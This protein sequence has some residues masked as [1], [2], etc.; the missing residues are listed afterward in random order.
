LVGLARFAD[1]R[2]HGVDT[3]DGLSDNTVRRI[4]QEAGWENASPEWLDGRRGS[5]EDRSGRGAP[6]GQGQSSNPT[7]AGQQG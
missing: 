5:G 1:D 3:S 6:M 7:A 4:A 2:F